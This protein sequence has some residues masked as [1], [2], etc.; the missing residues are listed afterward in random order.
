MTTSR[1]PNTEAQR[2]QREE[3]RREKRKEREKNRK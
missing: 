3:G 1:I 2:T